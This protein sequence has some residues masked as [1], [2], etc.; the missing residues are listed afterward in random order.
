MIYNYTILYIYVCRYKCHC[1][2]L[3][4]GQDA[5]KIWKKKHHLRV[6]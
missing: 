4:G 5:C 2:L 3:K 6:S 1:F